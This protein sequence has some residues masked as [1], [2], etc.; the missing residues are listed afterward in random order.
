MPDCDCTK[1]PFKP[2]PPCFGRC[3]AKILGRAEYHDLTEIFGLPVDL[4]Q[5]IMG[6]RGRSKA[7]SVT[8]YLTPDDF[9][10]IRKAFE[11]L[12]QSRL[13]RFWKSEESAAAEIINQLRQSRSGAL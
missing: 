8:D 9:L 6:F 3:V 10:M 7:V 13:D 4:S 11:D 2:N 12:S 5:K 1:V